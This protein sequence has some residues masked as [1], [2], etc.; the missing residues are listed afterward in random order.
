MKAIRALTAIES[1]Q[2]AKCPKNQKK[3]IMVFGELLTLTKITLGGGVWGLFSVFEMCVSKVSR[4]P[5]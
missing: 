1:G 3:L 4:W 5:N 2:I